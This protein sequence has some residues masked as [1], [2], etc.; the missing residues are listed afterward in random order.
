VSI[1]VYRIFV[2]AGWGGAGDLARMSAVLDQMQA[3]LYRFDQVADRD[4][5]M[6]LGDSSALETAIR[7]AMTQSHIA[8][9]RLTPGGTSS[10]VELTERKIA[11]DGFRRQIPVIGV[12][13]GGDT[14]GID[15]LAHKVDRVVPLNADALAMAIQELTE[16]A[17]ADRRRANEALLSRP[18]QL[19]AAESKPR[20]EMPVIP[21]DQIVEA[22]KALK[23]ARD[24]EPQRR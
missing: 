1:G 12:V 3:L 4:L 14:D 23:A 20:D 8:L 9:A 11:H 16:Q 5:Q 19:A 18:M 15:A 6:A 21:Y 13:D 10:L 7:I 22:Y 24:L 2:S 17:S